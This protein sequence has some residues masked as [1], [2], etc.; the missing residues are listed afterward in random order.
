M[1]R[2]RPQN[3]IYPYFIDSS[4]KLYGLADVSKFM[5]Y[6]PARKPKGINI[7]AMMVKTFMTSFI[8]LLILD[9]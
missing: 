8:L 3:E 4:G 9:R 5:P 7:V 2:A 6:T 1:N